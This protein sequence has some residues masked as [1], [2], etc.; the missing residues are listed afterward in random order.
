[1][2]GGSFADC[3]LQVVA[4]GIYRDKVPR[5]RFTLTLT[6]VHLIWTSE[7]N[8]PFF[9]E[10]GSVFHQPS[11]NS[12]VQIHPKLLLLSPQ[13]ISHSWSSKGFTIEVIFEQINWTMFN[14]HIFAFLDNLRRLTIRWK[15]LVFAIVTD[16]TFAF[17][18]QIFG[19]SFSLWGNSVKDG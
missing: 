8:F 5:W 3:C 1:M 9:Q 14:G 18:F 11:R 17:F 4:V 10:E 16:P 13:S 7:K 19:S 6:F 15:I 2:N 12:G